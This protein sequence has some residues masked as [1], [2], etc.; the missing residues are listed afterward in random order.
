MGY[1]EVGRK[2]SQGRRFFR[3]NPR[4]FSVQRLRSKFF[5]LFRLFGR[6]RSS[7]GLALESLKKGMM[8]GGRRSS[9]SS[10]NRNGKESRGGRRNLVTTPIISTGT[11]AHEFR[12]RSFGRSNS[13]YSEAISDCLEFIKRS[14][15]SVDE[16][17]Q[18]SA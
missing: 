9:C 8:M 17:K 11:R 12:L 1:T 14:S 10:R 2:P 4:K 7:Y 18:V 3:L 13:F 16:S 6:W 15:V 5:C